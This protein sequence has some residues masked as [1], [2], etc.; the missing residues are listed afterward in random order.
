MAAGALEYPLVWEQAPDN[1]NAELE[2]GGR[3]ERGP[4]RRALMPH[5][6]CIERLVVH[7]DISAMHAALACRCASPCVLLVFL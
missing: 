3:R 7:R 1:D 4:W 5:T 6:R 2:R